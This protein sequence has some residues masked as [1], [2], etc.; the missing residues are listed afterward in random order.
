MKTETPYKM[1]FFA[2]LITFIEEYG[3]VIKDE[4]RVQQN[5]KMRDFLKAAKNLTYKLQKDLPPAAEQL[6][7]EVVDNLFIFEQEF[8]KAVKDAIE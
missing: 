2:S 4:V 6:N 3:Y 1:M 8:I 7:D 5:A